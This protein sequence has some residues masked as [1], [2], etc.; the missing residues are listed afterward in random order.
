MNRLATQRLVTY[1]Y[2]DE[3][4]SV[5]SISALDL[6]LGVAIDAFAVDRHPDDP[7][8]V[9]ARPYSMVDGERSDSARQYFLGT[10]FDGG[11]I[12]SAAWEDEMC[13]D[14][15]PEF[16]I[17]KCRRYVQDNAL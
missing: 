11:I 7:T 2:A 10:R 12:E 17:A 6:E 14:G 5:R 15:A 1:D 13:A 3:V 8:P 9:Y 16:V 4:S